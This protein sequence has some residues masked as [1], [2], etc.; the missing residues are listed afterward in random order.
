M[1]WR[2]GVT[3]SPIQHSLTPKM[4]QYALDLLGLEG[5]AKHVEAGLDDTLMVR[6][7]MP[8]QFDALSVTMPL[9]KALYGFCD[10]VDDRARRIGAVNSILWQDDQ[11]QGCNFDGV[12]LVSAL[13]GELGVSLDGMHVTVLGSG[14]SAHAIID[15]VIDAGAESVSVHAR[16]SEAVDSLCRQYEKVSPAALIYRPI[17]LIVNTTPS[18]SRLVD[19]D[20]LQGVNSSTVAV[21]ITYQPRESQWL[22]LHAKAGCSSMNGLPMLAYQASLQFKWWFDHEVDPKDLLELIS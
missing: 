1:I 2:V 17:D 13:S 20:V 7:L 11:L 5:T 3:G 9:K 8:D 18:E 22:N 10:S 12:G 4:Q 15:G 16:N 19:G 14:G 6:G 21:D